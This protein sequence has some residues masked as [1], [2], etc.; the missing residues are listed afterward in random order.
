MFTHPKSVCILSA[1]L[2]SKLIRFSEKWLLLLSFSLLLLLVSSSFSLL[3]V[4]LRFRRKLLVLSALTLPRLN[5]EAFTSFKLTLYNW[6][7]LSWPATRYMLR[8]KLTAEQF[9]TTLGPVSCR[10]ISSAMNLS[11]SWDSSNISWNDKED[12]VTLE[13]VGW[14]ACVDN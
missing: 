5:S 3:R 7:W 14:K 8:F 12:L 6:Q 13:T 2:I 11:L 10:I 4:F 9:I 1:A